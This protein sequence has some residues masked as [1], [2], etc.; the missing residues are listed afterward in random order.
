MFLG[1][2]TN[3]E[4]SGNFLELSPRVSINSPAAHCKPKF[5]VVLFLLMFDPTAKNYNELT[6]GKKNYCTWNLP[7][8]IV[9]QNVQEGRNILKETR[10]VYW[11]PHFKP[12]QQEFL[13]LT[14]CQRS[15]YVIICILP[16][17]G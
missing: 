10:K 9:F 14:E 5:L 7:S 8:R 13:T 12:L 4:I 17:H 16:G 11:T 1:K 2:D 15:T 6:G 3:L